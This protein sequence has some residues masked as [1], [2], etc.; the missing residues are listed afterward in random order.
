MPGLGR[1]RTKRKRARCN[2]VPNPVEHRTL[3]IER[4]TANGKLT[5]RAT[6]SLTWYR[7][8]PGSVDTLAHIRN[9]DVAVQF[10]YIV[11]LGSATRKVPLWHEHLAGMLALLQ[12]SQPTSPIP[13]PEGLLACLTTRQGKSREAIRG[14]QTLNCRVGK[15]PPTRREENSWRQCQNPNSPVAKHLPS[16][17]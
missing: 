16:I 17:D 13:R 8:L 9:I 15:P 11:G 10:L 1:Y 12:N 3:M 4:Q 7:L 2:A 5:A 6:N 14:P